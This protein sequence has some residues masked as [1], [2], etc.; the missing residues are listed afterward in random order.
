[1]AK[2]EEKGGGG[3]YSNGSEIIRISPRVLLNKFILRWNKIGAD[4]RRL[5]IIIMMMLGAKENGYCKM[6]ECDE[7]KEEYYSWK[8]RKGEKSKIKEAVE[9]RRKK[10]KD[11]NRNRCFYI[12]WLQH[13][14]IAVILQEK[15]LNKIHATK[16]YFCFLTYISYV[17]KTHSEICNLIIDITDCMIYERMHLRERIIIQEVL[18]FC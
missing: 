12:A 6:N 2:W 9:E 11:D 15:K 8:W 4:A 16:T 1:M 3:V 7:E 5:L 14:C 18:R 17:Y 10:I 13:F